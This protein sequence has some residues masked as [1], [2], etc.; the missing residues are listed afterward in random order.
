VIHRLCL[1]WGLAGERIDIQANRLGIV[2]GLG[3][4]VAPAQAVQQLRD[5]LAARLLQ[6]FPQ[7]GADLPS[8][9]FWAS[10]F[11][12]TGGTL[13]GERDINRFIE[14]T[15]RAQGFRPRR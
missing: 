11:L 1:A 14:G 5:G 12:L 4:D 9:R 3:A 13:P 6:T 2:L 7:L 15:R 10:P 8:G